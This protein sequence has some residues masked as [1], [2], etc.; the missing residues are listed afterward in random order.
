MKVA[1]RHEVTLYKKQWIKYKGSRS[2][3]VETQEKKNCYELLL[4]ERKTGKLGGSS[5]ED[6]GGTAWGRTTKFMIFEKSQGPQRE[7]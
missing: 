3:A 1:T 6:I 4:R 7:C 5:F 2:T